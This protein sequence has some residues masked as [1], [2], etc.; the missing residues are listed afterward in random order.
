M[1]F[2]KS[3]T[4]LFCLFAHWTVISFSQKVDSTKNNSHFTGTISVTNNGISLIPTF[5]LGKPA[6]IFELSAGR[7]RFSF[8]PQMRF[9]LENGKPWSF[10][11]W[12]RYKLVETEKFK[13][14]IG[15]HSSFVFSNTTITT[16]GVVKEVITTKRFWASELSPQY[17]L[18][19]HV[20]LGV[21]YLYAHRIDIDATKNTHFLALNSR[22]SNINLSHQFYMTVVPQVFYLK[23]D[24]KDGFYMN[25]T[26]TL[27]KHN[28][29]FA[30][31]T[32]ASKTIHSNIGTKD[33]VWNVSLAYSF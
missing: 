12:M 19:K 18:S 6:A 13:L 26:L 24:E 22:I 8:D 27:A 29:P 23:L 17:A 9:N 5:S 2:L 11:F 33:F 28:S 30:L 15:T 16:N 3:K 4:F 7:K 1:N 14:N 31:S 10:V 20:S 25:A 32:I 21:Y